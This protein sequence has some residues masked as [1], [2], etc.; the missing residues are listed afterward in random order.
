MAET[1]FGKNDPRTQT[2]WSKKMFQYATEQ[3]FFYNGGYMGV[4][5]NSI[6]QID[7]D[8]E[9]KTGDKIV[10]K[11]RAPLTGPGSG[12]DGNVE[13]NEEAL[14]IL[15]FPLEVHERSHGVACAGK[16]SAKRTDTHI[17]EE[18]RD[19]LGAWLGE[20]IEDD[21][22]AALAGLYN[23]ASVEV[24]HP[25]ETVNEKAPSTY[26]H[27][28]GGQKADGTLAAKSGLVAHAAVG[29]Y[30]TVALLSAETAT[31][32]LF[33]RNV[34]SAVKRA[35]MTKYT[36][37]TGAIVYKVR[38]IKVKGKDYYVMAIH[39]LQAKALRAE[40][41]EAGW[42]A[43]VA[44][45]AK[46]GDDHPLFTGAMGVYDGVILHE[47][48]RIPI[49]TGANGVL[50]SEGF[51]LNAGR[52]ATTDAVADGKTV[53]RALFLG[54]QAAVIG[55][56]QVPHWYEDA[57]DVNRKP[58]VAT[59][60]IYG[61]SKTRFRSYAASTNTNTDEQDFGCIAVDTQVVVD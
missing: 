53:A 51:L 49:R 48:D 6:I 13:G 4:D 40:T 61:V 23:K 39:P 32:V 20:Q 60:M 44:A 11:L 34:I 30:P 46:R 31:N 10:F 22:V 43:I 3:M 55:W 28:L 52:T 29:D 35:A 15:N 7:K 9:K 5:T 36:T 8:L 25:I 47:Y 19:S 26:R 12:D 1:A 21:I 33:G 2:T 41:G 58:R 18:G 17:R 54:A 27:W 42:T 38:P 16:M 37:S 45:A 14:S 56:G 57:Y 50:P 24:G 59:D